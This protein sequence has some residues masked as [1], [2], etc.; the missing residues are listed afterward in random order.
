VK[1]NPFL[2]PCLRGFAGSPLADAS[3][4][5]SEL[6]TLDLK[7][8]KGRVE[9]HHP[10]QEDRDRSYFFDFSLRGVSVVARSS[11]G[12]SVVDFSL[13]GESVVD[14]LLRGDSVVDLSLRGDSALERS[15]WLE[16]S[17]VFLGFFDFSAVSAAAKADAQ[18]RM[19]RVATS[20]IFISWET[21]GAGSHH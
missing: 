7:N 12:D 19:S 18:V 15:L 4:L 14:L 10:T 20:L 11:F 17:F 9:D 6:R 5:P 8:K 13:R 1:Q 2:N 3:A 21:M 16:C